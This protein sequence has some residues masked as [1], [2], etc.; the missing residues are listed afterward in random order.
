MKRLLSLLLAALLLAAAC[1]SSLAETPD[2]IPVIPKAEITPTPAGLHHY[3]LI[4]IDSWETKLKD[5]WV[6]QAGQWSYHTD[7]LMLVTV[8]EYA[9]RV[10]L[11]S[12]I[13]DMLIM[14]PDGKYGRVNNFLDH[15]GWA[16]ANQK[17][18]YEGIQALVDTLGSHFNLNIEKFIV[19]NFKQVEN[20]VNAVG[21]VDVVLNSREI[22]R[23]ESF[24][25]Q[26]PPKNSDGSHHLQG[27]AAVMYMRIRKVHTVEYLHADG[28]V[29]ADTQD[30]GRTYR[31]RVVLSSI[32]EGLK[33]ITYEEALK[34]LDVIIANT[35]YTNM[36]TDDMLDAV[37]LVMKTRGIPVEHIR[38]PIDDPP[39][40]PGEKRTRENY[41]FEEFSYAGM[42]TKQINF[43][44]NREALH[45][46]LLDSFVV[47]D[48]E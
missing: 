18:D 40:A 21:G 4:C 31:D 48:E 25:I 34:L 2:P 44:L 28:K 12:F 3:L 9:E 5:K 41:S 45:K 24:G 26:L 7:G 29:Y 22:A 6:S 13:R 16:Y 19:V 42:A 33:D 1:P 15:A 8:D 43:L 11:T 30:Y 39:L 37:D 46:F 36:T 35:V 23:L 38:M 14:R 47:V 20:I 10:M 32:A 17:N 27:Y